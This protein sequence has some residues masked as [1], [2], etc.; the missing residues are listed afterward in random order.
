MPTECHC[1][2]VTDAE[3]PRGYV[4]REGPCRCDAPRMAVAR[5]SHRRVPPVDLRQPRDPAR[6][7]LG[8]PGL[9]PLERAVLPKDQ[10]ARYE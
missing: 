5:P 9:T 2:N 1:G 4:L 3:R 10:H 8:L 6:R 7:R